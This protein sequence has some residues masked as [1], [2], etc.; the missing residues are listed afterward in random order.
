M[1]LNSNTKHKRALSGYS[2][3]S[4]PSKQSS[5]LNM[6]LQPAKLNKER[7]ITP[8]KIN[9]HLSLMKPTTLNKRGNGSIVYANLPLQLND[10]QRRKEFSNSRL[11]N[12]GLNNSTSTLRSPTPNKKFNSINN[13]VKNV[14]TNNKQAHIRN[15]SGSGKAY[16]QSGFNS[17]TSNPE[18][19]K[20]SL[21]NFNNS[22]KKQNLIK[23][24]SYYIP[25]T[26][27]NDI[28]NNSHITNVSSKIAPKSG[29]KSKF[30]TKT[31]LKGKN[32]DALN[33]S[34][35]DNCNLS[36]LSSLS[37]ISGTKF[38]LNKKLLDNKGINRTNSDFNKT[39][40]P[41]SKSPLSSNSKLLNFNKVGVNPKV[42]LNSSGLGN[43]MNLHPASYASKIPKNKNIFKNPIQVLNNGTN[44]S[45]DISTNSSVKSK[46]EV[47]KNVKIPEKKNLE[48][49]T[50]IPIKY[51]KQ[52]NIN[53]NRGNNGTY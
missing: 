25:K 31:P 33:N 52:Q 43:N 15:L 17:V 16:K 37:G 46:M 48:Y 3:L 10:E 1:M 8:S 22:N 11:D 20:G 7:D 36:V 5:K 40:K 53:K 29:S 26:A 21:S 32:Q 51:E 2:D 28:L 35:L 9:N 6:P 27:R 19:M 50:Q 41:N 24:S 38:N 42:N 39:I 18:R 44:N 14:D 47:D 34:L 30:K 49:I 45:N 12:S 4:Y 13:K 23:N